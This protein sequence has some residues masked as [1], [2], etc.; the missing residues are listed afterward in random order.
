MSELSSSGLTTTMSEA[1]FFLRRSLRHPLQICSI[2]PSSPGVGEAMARAIAS[3]PAVGVVELGGGTG[4]VTRA[5]LDR[6]ITSSDLSSVEIDTELCE[7]LY[8]RY[9]SI[10]VLNVPAQNLSRIWREQSRAQVGGVVSTLPLKIFDEDM[11]RAVVSSVFDILKPGGRFVQFTYR[12]VSPIDK[13]I[14]DQ[15]GLIASRNKIVWQN[16]PPASIWIYSRAP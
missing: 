3:R 5:L 9:P 14:V 13:K 16:L 10:E 6:G 7:L 12:F 15:M 8:K 2:F 4:A 1:L 11:V